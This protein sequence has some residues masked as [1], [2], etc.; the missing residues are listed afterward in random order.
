MSGQRA[1]V[2]M[3]GG[4]DSAVAASLLR[5]QGWEVV[6]AT[7]R[8]WR[9]GAEGAAGSAEADNAEDVAAAAAACAQLA[10]PHRVVDQRA[11]FYRDVVE[12]FL[13]DYARGRTPNPC[14]RCNQR[15]KFGALLDAARAAGYT[16]LATGHYARVV[17]GAD[18][19]ELWRGAD[20]AKDQSYF[21][22]MLQTE[23]L[24][25][26]LLPLGEWTK[27]RVR[28][29]ARARGLAA[30]E[31]PESQ[32]ICFVGGAGYQRLIQERRPE[33]ARPGPIYDA[34][35]RHL[36]QHAGLAFFTVGQREG[37]RLAAPR[38]L[39]VLALDVARNALVVGHAEELGHDALLAEEMRYTAGQP[40]GAGAPVMAKI[41][42]R[43]RE[44][45]A[46]V[47]PL[48]DARAHIV[49]REPLRD[50]APG[51]AV[52]LYAGE[53]V[54]G[55]GIIAQVLGAQALHATGNPACAQGGDDRC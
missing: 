51:Q 18:G 39:Y 54:V 11:A 49:F 34:A 26:V 27:E 52:V 2:A 23:Q 3:S 42:Y 22:Y 19:W 46:V 4:V 29:Y 48:P 5:E 16:H 21:L 33:A 35:G 44:A 40:V 47:W 37:L 6:G 36:G 55:G 38:P 17:R 32:D 50:I 1:W 30:E 41:R 31:R 15:I 20:P 14:L 9:L 28:A 10:I 13:D 43:A 8:L 45:P 25:A 53:R 7:L 12:P 24:Q